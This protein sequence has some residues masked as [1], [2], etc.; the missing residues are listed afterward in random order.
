MFIRVS[1][2]VKAPV[3]LGDHQSS[4]KA[5]LQARV[6][7]AQVVSYSV[8]NIDLVV[9]R[10]DFVQSLS[11]ITIAYPRSLYGIFKVLYMK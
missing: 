11:T 3:V 8:N 5:H 2:D 9:R 1:H 7:A 6:S 10:T 4:C